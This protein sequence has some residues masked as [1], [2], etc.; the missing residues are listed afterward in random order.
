MMTAVVCM[1][2]ALVS[3]EALDDDFNIRSASSESVYFLHLPTCPRSNAAK[4][5]I[6]AKY[7]DAKVIYIDISSSKNDYIL[8]G[9]MNA[10]HL[11]NSAQTP[12]I[13]FGAN[14]IEGWDYSKEMILDEYIRN[15]LP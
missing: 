12:I 6:A 13:C 11:G 14:H 1:A 8:E 2:M 5:Y 7:P 9:A 15:Y 10:Y 3:C 4:A